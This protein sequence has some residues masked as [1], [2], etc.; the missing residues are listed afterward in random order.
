MGSAVGADFPSDTPKASFLLIPPVPAW[1]HP[2]FLGRHIS[3]SATDRPRCHKVWGHPAPGMA[4][5]APCRVKITC[6]VQANPQR[7]VQEPSPG[8]VGCSGA[9]PLRL[10]ASSC[11]RSQP[12]AKPP[13][14]P[15]GGKSR[16]KWLGGVNRRVC[17]CWHRRGPGQPRP[18]PNTSPNYL[19]L[20]QKTHIT[21]PALPTQ[22]PARLAAAPQAPAGLCGPVGCSASGPWFE[23]RLRVVSQRSVETKLELELGKH[24]G[25]PGVAEPTSVGTGHPS[26]P[27]P[28]AP[29]SH[30]APLQHQTTL[31]PAGPLG[32]F[33]V[34]ASCA[35][36]W[37]KL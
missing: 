5:G 32:C 12:P 27:I 30:P 4:L 33:A 36:L 24:R 10:C 29:R 8:L 26:A 2:A 14:K 19:Q 37:M 11:C 21:P 25:G 16:R 28:L 6:G 18:P 1:G 34:S 22:H 20:L 3:T 15:R 35:F 23:L 9:W 17:G 31:G 7:G 13:S